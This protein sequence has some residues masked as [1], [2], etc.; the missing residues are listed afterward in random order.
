MTTPLDYENTQSLN[1][2]VVTSDNGKPEPLFTTLNLKINV[3]DENDNSPKFPHDLVTLKEI[4]LPVNFT[5]HRKDIL[6]GQFQADDKDSSAEFRNTSYKV[7]SAMS[8][9]AKFDGQPI[10]LKKDMLVDANEDLFQINENGTLMLTGE[11]LNETSH[12]YF[13]IQ[14]E[15]FDQENKVSRFINFVEFKRIIRTT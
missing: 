11:F 2:T 6:I 5:A 7:L 10:H 12:N 1:L 3:I 15:A 8:R 14:I 13:L 9:E 4:N